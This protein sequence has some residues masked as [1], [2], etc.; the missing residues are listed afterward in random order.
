MKMNALL[1]AAC[2]L[3][4][5]M[6][7]AF[8]AEPHSLADEWEQQQTLVVANEPIY[9][10][11]AQEE[12]LSPQERIIRAQ[13]RIQNLT[14]ADA[15]YPIISHPFGE[16][17]T[18]GY[19]FSLNG[20]PLF[21]ILAS[22]LD[23]ADN[24]TLEQSANNVLQ[25]LETLRHDYIQQRSPHEMT[26]GII[27]SL[28]ATLLFAAL[29]YLC[30]V[31]RRRAYLRIATQSPNWL[32]KGSTFTQ[33]I[34]LMERSLVS[35]TAILVVLFMTY[36][37]L[38]WVLTRFPYTR[39]W[40]LHLGNALYS[41]VSKLA[42]NM[43]SALPGLATVAA[44]FLITR[45]LNQLLRLLFT[46]VEKGQMQLP[47]LHPETVGATRRLTSTVLW[48]FAITIAYPYLPG[49]NSDAF[50][51]MSVFFGLLI[52]LGS[53]GLMNH[54]MSGLVL[55][56]SRA[57]RK[58]DFVRIG[59]VE[60]TVTELNALSLKITTRSAHEIT[61]P[62][63]VVV[64]GTVENSSRLA[65]G[66]RLNVLTSVTIGYD[67]PWRQVK[68]MLE[69]AARR[70]HYVDQQGAIIVRQTGLQDFYVAYELQVTG[71]PGKMPPDIRTELHQHIQ[72]VFNEFAVQIMSPHFVAQPQQNVVVPPAAWFSAPAESATENKPATSAD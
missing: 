12:K 62:N 42:D 51:G 22:D 34:L 38:S 56:Y 5:G 61:L 3:L 25:R 46:S 18:A 49:A 44:I 57:L 14:T 60:G 15:M 48:L 55:V 6:V 58:G 53:A 28:A 27:L 29:L 19:H 2:L 50:K 8:A 43:I 9:L 70:C 35:L 45:L 13:T 59:N 10:F 52:T 67:T 41:L 39:P 17:V 20:K 36:T 66:N 24:L 69:L 47:G 26:T 4:A 11:L 40:G 1:W 71:M 65:V 33:F 32:S 54:A 23:P 21:N 64:S 63:A 37:W 30:F 16:G 68:A 72:D 7:P 31:A